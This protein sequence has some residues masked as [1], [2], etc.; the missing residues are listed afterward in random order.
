MEKITQ[1]CKELCN[2]DNAKIRD[3]ARVLG[4]LV[5][6]FSAVEFGP[7]FYR[8]TEWAKI[9]T[10]QHQ[11]GDYDAFMIITP[12][13]KQELSWWIKNLHNQQRN[14]CH[15]NPDVIITTDAS[16]F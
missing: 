13:M 10:L 14:I 9:Q 12:A 6:S 15:G 5:S 16:A 4:L 1:A 2:Q 3:V 8:T 7:L 11:A